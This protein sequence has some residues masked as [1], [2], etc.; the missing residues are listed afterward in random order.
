M[1]V[2]ARA[3]KKMI[4]K[5]GAVEEIGVFGYWHQYGY[6]GPF[7]TWP[8]GKF[9]V[10][11]PFETVRKYADKLKPY[12]RRNEI[13]GLKH[14]IRENRPGDPFVGDSVLIVYTTK[15]KR[16][17]VEEILKNE[18]IEGAKWTEKEPTISGMGIRAEIMKSERMDENRQKKVA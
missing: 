17:T 2:I 6:K 1:K 8:Q 10:R 12:V 9:I 11:A 7:S 16:S 13:I 14:P 3:K 15:K 18:G 5:F 4:S